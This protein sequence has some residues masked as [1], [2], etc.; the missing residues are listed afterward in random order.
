M[1]FPI[2]AIAAALLILP[3]AQPASACDTAAKAS[4]QTTTI[5]AAL[6]LSAA[7]HKKA[8]KKKSAKKKKAKVEYMR[9]APMK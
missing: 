4:A 5:T 1:R 2:F 8:M 7:K 9:A 3:V 6:D